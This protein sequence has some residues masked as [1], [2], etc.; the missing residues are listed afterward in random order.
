MPEFLHH[1]AFPGVAASQINAQAVVALAPGAGD[2]AVLPADVGDEPFGVAL[3]AASSPGDAVTVH[4]RGNT[5]QA[6]AA[7]SFGAG[8]NVGVAT[9]NAGL[10]PVAS[11]ALR[12]GQ[13]VT[14]AGPGETFSL[15]VN[16]SKV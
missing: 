12:A 5:V 8:A 4:D 14:P 11:G 10:R 6:I 7:A 9:V 16:P 13:S 15:Y 3:A 2:R 1:H